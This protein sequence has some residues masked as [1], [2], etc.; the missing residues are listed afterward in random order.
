VLVLAGSKESD[1]EEC[2]AL[3]RAVEGSDGSGFLTAV[4]AALDRAGTDTE[5][6]A[7]G[8]LAMDFFDFGFGLILRPAGADFVSASLRSSPCLPLIGTASGSSPSLDAVVRTWRDRAGADLVSAFPWLSLCAAVDFA[9]VVAGADDAEAAEGGLEAC[10]AAFSS[11]S[12]FV[13]ATLL[14]FARD[15]AVEADSAREAGRDLG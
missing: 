4:A 5:A 2:A 8:A 7:K 11:S 15:D 9:L 12:S 6:E 10:C 1:V 3:L 14:P 13:A